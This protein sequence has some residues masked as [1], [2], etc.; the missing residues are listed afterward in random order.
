MTTTALPTR[1]T[2]HAPD[3]ERRGSVEKF[4]MHVE[5]GHAVHYDA[6]TEF[7]HLLMTAGSEVGG[8]DGG[9]VLIRFDVDDEPTTVVHVAPPGGWWPAEGKAPADMILRG[10][11]Y[12]RVLSAKL[13]KFEELLDEV[14]Q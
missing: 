10:A 4:E 7:A 1:Q 12:L 5:G 9:Y 6:D 13:E 8:A 14:G 3:R 2:D 11:E